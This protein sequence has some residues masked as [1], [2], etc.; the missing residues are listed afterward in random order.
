V[1]SLRA[2]TEPSDA[3]CRLAIQTEE[4]LPFSKT[5]DWSL[6]ATTTL[7]HYIVDVNNNQSTNSQ[8]GIAA[9]ARHAAI[10]VTHLVR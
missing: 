5:V 8:T 1:L 10:A 2:W 3:I 9:S 6:I 4:A 7:R